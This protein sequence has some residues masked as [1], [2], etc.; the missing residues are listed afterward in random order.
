M[1]VQLPSKTSSRLISKDLAR[2]KVVTVRP[3]TKI[4]IIRLS[5]QTVWDQAFS[6][7]LLITFDRRS[8]TACPADLV[9]ICLFAALLL[10]AVHLII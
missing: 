1:E 8:T 2:K 5:W 9:R 10:M 6:G 7:V 3:N 4:M